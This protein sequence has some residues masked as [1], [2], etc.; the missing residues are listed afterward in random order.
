MME[1]WIVAIVIVAMLGYGLG[2]RM[3]LNKSLDRIICKEAVEQQARA[4]AWH[5]FEQSGAR[6]SFETAIKKGGA[7]WTQ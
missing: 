6:E 1:V 7:K 4:K 3:S 5:A 2:R